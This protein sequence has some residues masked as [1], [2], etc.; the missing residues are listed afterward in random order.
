MGNMRH[1][2]AGLALGLSLGLSATGVA[3][4][5]LRVSP[6]NIELQG[7]AATSEVRI[8]N[9]ERE[10]VNAQVR[11]YRWTQ[12]GGQNRLEPTTDV[13]ASPPITQL[14]GGSE[15]LIRIVRVSER[16]IQGTERYRLLVDELPDPADQAPGRVNVVVRHSIPVS[17][18]E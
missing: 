9:N 5:S 10:P 8:W 4:S 13:V 1:L 12:S 15:N 14:S 11:V 7:G 16:P 3:A 17:F 2:A 6:I 18:S